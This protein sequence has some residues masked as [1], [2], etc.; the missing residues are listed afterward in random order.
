MGGKAQL[1]QDRFFFTIRTV[2][3]CLLLHEKHGVG[4][5]VKGVGGNGARSKEGGLKTVSQSVIC[6]NSRRAR[7]KIFLLLVVRLQ[8]WHV[9][10]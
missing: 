3:P 6:D 1:S 7:F 2:M 10:I 4:M 8:R 9:D 5:D